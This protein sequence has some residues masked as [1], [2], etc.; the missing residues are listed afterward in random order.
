MRLNLA[1]WDSVK[2]FAEQYKKSKLPIHILMNNAGIMAPP[3]FEMSKHAVELQMAG[4]HLGH[5]YLTLLL[6][7]IIEKTA[8]ANKNGTVRIV[9]LSSLAH[10]GTYWRGIDFNNINNPRTY[11]AWLAYGQSKLANLL[12]SNQLQ[13]RI[14]G[15]LG[16][17]NVFVNAVHPGGV[18]TN[19]AVGSAYIRHLY[20]ATFAS[21]FIL[22]SEQGS[23]T[24]LYCATSEEIP[25]RGLKARYFVP[26]ASLATPSWHGRD[27]R[28][29]EEL[30]DWSVA[31]LEKKGFSVPSV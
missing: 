25:R 9:N 3:L 23:L 11:N 15:R 18:A 26:T 16:L 19:L 12:F 13:K 29:A 22:T 17:Q 10:W 2:S 28:L 20:N 4:N 27:E 31:T 21:F 6:M 7:P 1:D 8:N 30:W 14:E 5:F 24:Q